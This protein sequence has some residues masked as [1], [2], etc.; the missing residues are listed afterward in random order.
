MQNYSAQQTDLNNFIRDI[1][2]DHPCNHSS[3]KF[4]NTNS[5]VFRVFFFKSYF[6]SKVDFFCQQRDWE[7]FS[8]TL[9]QLKLLTFW[10]TSCVWDWCLMLPIISLNSYKEFSETLKMKNRFLTSFNCITFD[11]FPWK[12]RKFSSGSEVDKLFKTIYFLH[13]RGWS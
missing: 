3:T 10:N 11:C 2:V 13:N 5:N 8:F 12:G 9:C 4:S 1:S 6:I 7:T